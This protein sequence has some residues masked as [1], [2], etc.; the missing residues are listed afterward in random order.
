[1]KVLVYVEGE[2]DTKALGSLFRGVI[3]RGNKSGVGISFI[4]MKGK[5]V[6]LKDVGL[7]AALHLRSN[8]GDYVFA[9]PDL[10]PMV[11]YDQS[12]LRHRSFEE[13]REM[14]AAR[15]RREADRQR[16]P[17]GVRA[18]YRVHCLKH[19]LE[20]LLLGAP[21]VLRQRL[22][23][24]D[25]IEK[26]WREPVEDQNGNKPPK[27]IVGDLFKKYCRRSYI[28]TTDAPWVLERASPQDLCSEC[29][30]NFRPFFAEL[31]R[32]SKGEQLE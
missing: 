17:D 12:E 3:D 9:L 30:Q 19:E 31:D 23:T 32:L 10:Y 28:E 2:G 5:S 16:L 27:R 14:L 13:L 22:K 20:V 24:T 4:H 15:F 8:P 7:K 21:E 6:L 26:N 29:P 18:H 11:D 25:R 1:V